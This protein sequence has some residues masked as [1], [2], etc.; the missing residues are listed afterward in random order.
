MKHKT[1]VLQLIFHEK[2]SFVFFLK[3]RQLNYL[4]ELMCASFARRKTNGPMYGGEQPFYKKRTREIVCSKDI[5]VWG[6]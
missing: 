4:N 6:N 3:Y 1:I 2:L 5:P